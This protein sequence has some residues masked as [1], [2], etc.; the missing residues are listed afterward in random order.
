MTDCY[1]SR[2]NNSIES[3]FNG[4]TIIVIKEYRL[5][6]LSKSVRI[7]VALLGCLHLCGGHYGV[8]QAF[9]WSKMLLDYS[10]QDGLVVGAI[11]TFDGNHPCC[12]CK[13]IGAAKKADAEQTK[14]N[15]MSV[16]G[17]VLKEVVTSREIRAKA[18]SLT[19]AVPVKLPEML[20]RGAIFGVSP[21][22]PPPRGVA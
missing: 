17:L 6:G 22:V 18:P 12:M 7:I 21:P 8:F 5:P 10:Q 2:E 20:V 11:K 3:R 14:D 4:L 16:S 19:D 13:Q 9:A 15:K 1:V